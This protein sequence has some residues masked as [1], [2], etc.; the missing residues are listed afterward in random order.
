MGA[1]PT[2]FMT[3]RGAGDLL[4]RTTAIL[5]TIFFVLS[6]T[7]TIVAGRAHGGGSIVDRLKV[8]AL[9]PDALAKP[10]APAQAPPPQ[11]GPAGAPAGPA[12][13]SVFSAPTPQVNTAPSSNGVNSVFSA[14]APTAGAPAAGAPAQPSATPAAPAQTPPKK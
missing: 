9:N 10:Q 3:A 13:P 1:G 14:P 7:L 5:A 12:A 2:G 11:Q 6:L 8:D 4:T